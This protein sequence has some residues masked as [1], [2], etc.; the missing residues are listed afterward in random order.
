VKLQLLHLMDDI[1]RYVCDVCTEV[2]TPA[3]GWCLDVLF[4]KIPLSGHGSIRVQDHL[5]LYI[6]WPDEVK[7]PGPRQ[8]RLLFF[9]CLFHVILYIILIYAS[10]SWD[11]QRRAESPP[12]EPLDRACGQAVRCRREHIERWHIHKQGGERRS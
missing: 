1:L 8:L 4:T 2:P 5:P 3:A 9:I 6:L 11:P 10:P 7:P 12:V